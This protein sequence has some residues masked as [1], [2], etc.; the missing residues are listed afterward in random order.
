MTKIT[1]AKFGES[2]KQR[3][4]QNTGLFGPTVN[5]KIGVKE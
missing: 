2:L 5:Q 3:L 1:T 4:D